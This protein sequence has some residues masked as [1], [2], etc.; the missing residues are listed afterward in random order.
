MGKQGTGEPGEH[1]KSCIGSQTEFFLFR[2]QTGSANHVLSL[3]LYSHYN[4]EELERE[5]FKNKNKAGNFWEK[6]VETYADSTWGMLSQERLN[7]RE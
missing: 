6:S 4:H 2:N 1:V 3:Q 7:N 5:I